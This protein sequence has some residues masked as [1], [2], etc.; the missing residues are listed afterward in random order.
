[1]AAG[2]QIALPE[3]NE[4]KFEHRRHWRVERPAIE[5]GSPPMPIG[6]KSGKTLTRDSSTGLEKWCALAGDSAIRSS[7]ICGGGNDIL[8]D[9]EMKI[10]R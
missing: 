9:I 1:M 3:R 8:Y 6:I 10:I 5:T 4:A 2:N 7:S